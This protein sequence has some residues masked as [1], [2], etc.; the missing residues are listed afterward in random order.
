MF[1]RIGRRRFLKAAAGTTLAAGAAAGGYLGTQ[2]R[3]PLAVIGTGLRGSML[4]KTIT[5]RFYRSY[6]DIVAVCDVDRLR[7]EAF[8]QKY[9]QHADLYEDHRRVLQ[10]DDVRAVLIA[11]PD[12]WH[13]AIAI[14][15]L[16]AGKAVYCEKPMTLTINEGRQLVR[17]VQETNGLLLGG[18]QQRSDWR[19][20]RACELV[21]NGRLGKLKRV[22]VQLHEN[23]KGGPFPQQR[24]PAGLNWDRWLGQAPSVPFCPERCRDT[25]RYWYEYGGGEITEWGAH[26]V[27]IAHWAMGMDDSGPLEIDGEGTLPAVDNGFNVPQRFDIEMLYPGDVRLKIVSSKRKGILI[28]GERGRIFVNRAVLDGKPVEQLQQ[29]PLPSDAVRLGHGNRYWRFGSAKNVHLQH[30]LDCVLTGR[31]P[32]CDVASQHRSVSACHLA[33][34]CLRL[35]RKLRWDADAQRFHDD[36]EANSMLARTRR[37]DYQLGRLAMR[38]G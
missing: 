10:R 4:A 9:C 30:F 15:A 21:H 11:T 32:I 18:T 24:V 8:R 7:A 22:T 23:P 13:A 20:Q 37:D 28:E 27:D 36:D 2:Q 25:F 34:L 35:G 19:F 38:P 14:E 3:V 17:A 29:N 5:R 16:R 1:G 33:N 6:G 12:H 26:H 31:T